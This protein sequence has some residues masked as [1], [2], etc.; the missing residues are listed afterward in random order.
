[1]DV[2]TTP[3]CRSLHGRLIPMAHLKAQLDKIVSAN[4]VA[5]TI[6]ARDMTQTAPI[7]GNLPAN[8][9]IPPYH[10]NCRTS[11]LADYAATRAVSLPKATARGTARENYPVLLEPAYSRGA[12][13]Q[14]VSA[15]TGKTQTKTVRFGALANDGHI[16][17][18][19]DE[20]YNHRSDSR[21][22][23]PPEGNIRAALNSIL[24]EADGYDPK[25]GL[26]TGRT[27]A[28]CENNMILVF[29]GD[30]VLTAFYPGDK[31]SA[32]S[33]F[34]RN[35]IEGTRQTIQQPK[36]IKW[37]QAIKELFTSI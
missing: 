37:L 6:A 4:S 36:V 8:I 28:L 24:M 34:L 31:K 14:T 20:T 17:V 16:R 19:T 2:K 33:Y 13:I 12:K 23:K 32:K 15:A 22:V 29:D 27:I 25:L 7:Y 21:S 5:A 26:A 11:L 1:M 9:G 30:Y 3:I 10:F 18:V 35:S